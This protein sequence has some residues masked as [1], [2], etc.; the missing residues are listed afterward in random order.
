MCSRGI[1]LAFA[2]RAMNTIAR[3]ILEHW[4][5]H[6]HAADSAEGICRWWLNDDGEARAVEQVER[7]LDA[8]VREGTAR[9]VDLADG[10]TLYVLVASGRRR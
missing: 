3:R 10:T 5:A 2:T 1:A 8:L 9:R 4:D 7:V 6:P